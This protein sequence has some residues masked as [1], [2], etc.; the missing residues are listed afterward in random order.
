[1]TADRCLGDPAMLDASVTGQPLDHSIADPEP[2][3]A[4]T[5]DVRLAFGIEAED[6]DHAVLQVETRLPAGR[7]EKAE[8]PPSGIKKR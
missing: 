1:M 7:R 2:E 8:E 5:F 4:V 3:V 6:G